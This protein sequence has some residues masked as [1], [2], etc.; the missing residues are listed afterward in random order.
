MTEDARHELDAR[1][2]RGL[3][4][5]LRVRLL[6]LLRTEGPA[7]ATLLADRVGERSGT[8][9]WH[10]R[11]LAEHGFIQQDEQRGNRRERW[12]R[13]A[14]DT[15]SVATDEFVDDPDLRAS[16]EVLLGA[17]A[18][19]HYRQSAEFA[20]TLHEWSREWVRAS[21]MSDWQLSLTAAELHRLTT[22]VNDL[23][24]RY[25]RDP[26]SGDERVA[27]QVQAFPQRGVTG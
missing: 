20:F 12:W 7:T 27:L 3:A 2:L 14:Q 21:E 15:T 26:R 4:H 22:Q 8:T 5:P 13:A 16:L 23:V 25:Q 11:Q 19:Q 18:A 17:F 9:S 24:A 10:L 1:S 6:G